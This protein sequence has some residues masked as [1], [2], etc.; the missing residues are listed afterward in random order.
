MAS[1]V[2][3]DLQ[4]QGGGRVITSAS[5]FVTGKFRWVQVITDTQFSVFEAENIVN[6]DGLE[7][8]PIFAGIGIGGLITALTVS[9]GVVIAYDV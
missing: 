5:G 9:S 8:I 7:S 3:Y 2:S 4:G 6:A 1:P